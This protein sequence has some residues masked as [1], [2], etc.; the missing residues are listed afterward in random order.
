MYELLTENTNPYGNIMNIELQVC[1]KP[2]FRPQIP[3]LTDE[4]MLKYAE[5]MQN[6]WSHNAVLRPT[7]DE[8]VAN[9]EQCYAMLYNVE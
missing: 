7:C 8:L 3:V 6:C 2:D 9:L 4:S 1:Q 5:I